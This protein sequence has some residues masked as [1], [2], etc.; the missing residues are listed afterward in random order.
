MQGKFT[1]KWRER[2]LDVYPLIDLSFTNLIHKKV[3]GCRRDSNSY[4]IFFLFKE[5]FLLI[6]F[7]FFRLTHETSPFFPFL[8]YKF[9]FKFDFICNIFSFFIR[10]ENYS[11]KFIFSFLA[12]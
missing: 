6:Q 3:P 7:F 9:A 12:L 8:I 4:H 11:E 2:K 10:K 1:F 5:E